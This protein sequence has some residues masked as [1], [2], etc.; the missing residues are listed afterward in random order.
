MEELFIYS[1]SAN[2]DKST[3]IQIKDEGSTFSLIEKSIEIAEIRFSM[4]N[5][6][7]PRELLLK[8]FPRNENSTWTV[9]KV[10]KNVKPKYNSLKKS[11]QLNLY[12][13]FA[14]KSC[15]NCVLENEQ[16]RKIVIVRKTAKNDIDIEVTKEIDPKII[17]FI[18]ISSFL[19]S[20]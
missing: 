6:S 19:C 3:S 17:F 4:P 5:V 9:P 15:K 12:G 16:S 7:F 10:L 8:I 20:I 11:W 13:K 2:I 1:N 14:L 18:G